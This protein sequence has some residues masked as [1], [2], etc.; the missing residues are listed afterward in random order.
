MRQ[1]PQPEYALPFDEDPSEYARVLAEVHQAIRCGGRPPAKPRPVID[2]SWK[3][4]LRGGVPVDHRAPRIDE[5]RVAQDRARLLTSYG[6]ASATVLAQ[7]DAAL[8]PA[9]SDSRLI[10]MVSTPD[11]R[12]IHRIG[13][14]PALGSADSLGFVEGADW[15]EQSVGT[16]AIGVAALMGGP[17]QILG[18]EH[19]CSS[20]HGWSCSAA[21]V[22]DPATGQIL[23]IIDVS[24]P[25][26][27]AHPA[28]LGMVQALTG[29][30]EFML[31]DA[32]HRRLAKLRA[33]GPRRGGFTPLSGL[34][35]GGSAGAGGATASARAGAGCA[36]GSGRWVLC[37]PC[38][39][40]ADSSGVEVGE[41]L[42]LGVGLVTGR[43]VLRGLGA[44]EV[45][46]SGAGVLVV[47]LEHGQ[48]TAEYA[49][50]FSAGT[51]T[52]TAAGEAI[53][54]SVCPRH[55]ELLR[56]LRDSTVPLKAEALSEQVWGGTV[57]PVTVRAEISRLR[58][59]FP[60][61]VSGSPYH[62]L[63]D[64]SMVG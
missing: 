48:P 33:A 51:L 2:R 29:Q 27:T 53:T 35:A 45:H 21:P 4:M 3:R 17:V 34:S 50:D 42:N 5:S 36:A 11:S 58:K 14:R 9:L 44:V 26:A 59:R 63:A 64:L 18:P 47:P 25:V 39:W 12:I 7:V 8:A 31:R 40:V 55:A 24:G 6:D 49:L 61:L 60:D 19:W 22:R 57:T 30:I 15:A 56:A 28:I 10:G 54:Q 32:H 20:H 38:G 41:Q 16:N 52:V 1:T 13:D 37:D 43:T 23:A 46:R 62:L